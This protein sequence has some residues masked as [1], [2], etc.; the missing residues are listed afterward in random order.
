MGRSYQITSVFT[1]FS[2]LQNIA[3]AVQAHAGHSFRFWRAAA[4][5]RRL[6]EPAMAALEKVGLADRADTPVGELA[7]GERRQ[8]EIAMV[9]AT[10]AKCCCWTSR[11]PA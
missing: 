6:R 4:S 10:G 5:E 1:D 2:V 11:W 8:L 3:L 7:H 9:L